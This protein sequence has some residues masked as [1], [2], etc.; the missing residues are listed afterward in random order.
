[1][2]ELYTFTTPNGTKASVMLEEIGIPYNVHVVHLGKNE[3]RAAEFLAIN[4]NGRIPAIIDTEGPGGKP[5]KVFESGAILI[6]LAEKSGKLLP[7]DPVR[8]M[9][10]IEW[11]M[12]QM[13]GVGPMFGQLGWFK[14]NG[15][16]N[17]QAITRYTD[18][19]ARLAGV[20]DQRLGEAEYLADEYSIADIA[21]FTWVSVLPFFNIPLDKTPNLRR[22]HEAIAARP[23]VQRGLKVPKV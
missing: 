9:E 2:I 13:A 17:Q 6:Y 1:M 5:L 14:R 15:A 20:L 16:D 23:A 4:P 22:W 19:S 3:Q 8:R 21:N 11:L 12:F 10:A 18:E 7:R